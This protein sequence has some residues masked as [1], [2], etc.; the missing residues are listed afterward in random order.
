M[1]WC[2]SPVLSLD[3]GHK[4]AEGQIGHE[5]EKPVIQGLQPEWMVKLDAMTK[6]QPTSE[7]G[8][9]VA[10][11]RGPNYPLGPPFGRTH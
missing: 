10:K 11:T 1:G 6:Q 2:M 5:E 3:V 9:Y 8:S 4:G 7:N